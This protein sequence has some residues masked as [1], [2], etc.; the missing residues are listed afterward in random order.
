MSSSSPLEHILELAKS[1]KTPKVADSNMQDQTKYPDAQPD[2]GDL[3]AD[4]ASDADNTA[5][6]LP[7]HAKVDHDAHRDNED[8]HA[9]G[10]TMGAGGDVH[11]GAV[12]IGHIVTV[13]KA[14]NNRYVGMHHPSGAL[15]DAHQNRARAA[16]ALA[17][18]HHYMPH[19]IPTSDSNAQPVGCSAE[20]PRLNEVLQLAAT[21]TQADKKGLRTPAEGLK[22]YGKVAFADPRNEKYPISD[23]EQVRA[24]LGYIN[25]PH[26][27][28][29]YPLNGVT[30][31]EVKSKIEEAARKLGIEVSGS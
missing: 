25:K 6:E 21:K 29:E 24:A 4:D 15:T 19:N 11:H 8:M 30:L 7:A 1:S 16:I 31:S 27:A 9:M 26:N 20:T 22:K 2:M 13:P 10:V 23:E 14:K 3:N 5:D 17:N 18:L 12:K 28:S